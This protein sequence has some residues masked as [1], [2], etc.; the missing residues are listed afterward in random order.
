MHV[1]TQKRIWEAKAQ[2]PQAGS[3]LETWLRI[4]KAASPQTFADMKALFPAT[5][6]VGRFHVFDIGGNKIRLVADVHYNTGKVF[7]RAVL[8]HVGYD[9]GAWKE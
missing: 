4:M 9:K 1:V 3:A 5:D 7:I 8:D 6:K 2:W